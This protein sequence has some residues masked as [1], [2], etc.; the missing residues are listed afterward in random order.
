[1]NKWIIIGLIFLQP[2][3][4]VVVLCLFALSPLLIGIYLYKTKPKKIKKKLSLFEMVKN[5]LAD[6]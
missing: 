4:I 5:D 3:L 6:L 2:L 1:M